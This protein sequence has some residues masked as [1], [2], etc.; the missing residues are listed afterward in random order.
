MQ[1]RAEQPN[2]EIQPI[3]N[4]KRYHLLRTIE[5]QTSK[6]PVALAIV[7]TD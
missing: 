3:N 6:Y 4:C 7:Q 5:I 2:S 1:R